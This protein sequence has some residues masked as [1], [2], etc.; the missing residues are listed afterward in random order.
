V[1][2]EYE[3]STKLKPEI[4]VCTAANGAEEIT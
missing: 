1:A 3:R 2:Y 4:Y